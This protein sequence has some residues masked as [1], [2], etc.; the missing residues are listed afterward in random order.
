MTLAHYLTLFR[1]VISPFFLF[2]Y[3]EYVWLGIAPTTLPYILLALLCISEFT[4][5]CDGYFARRFDAVTDLG[6][7]ID[8]MADSISRLSVFMTLTEYPVKLPIFFVFLL[9]YRDSVISTLR[10]ICALQGTAL[11]ARS[12]GKIKA[13]LQGIAAFLVV[14][15]LIPHS[16]GELSTEQLQFF[17][18]IFVGIACAYSVYSGMDYLIAHRQ[19]L[20]KALTLRPR[21][22]GRG[23][24]APN[25]ESTQT[26][27]IKLDI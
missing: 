20:K 7:L 16:H 2:F 4:D 8:P 27:T 15:L 24:E 23:S 1:V 11:A 5:A 3:L 25:S 13:I 6:K 18:R 9:F 26:E 19:V 22:F 12:S 21:R 17:S 14:L 10:T